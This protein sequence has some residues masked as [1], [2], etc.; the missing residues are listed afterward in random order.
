MYY[1]V[2]GNWN[3]ILSRE[4]TDLSKWNSNNLGA[5]CR[6]THNRVN[7]HTTYLDLFLNYNGFSYFFRSEEW[8]RRGGSC[9]DVENSDD[10]EVT[11]SFYQCYLKTW[12]FVHG[13]CTGICRVYKLP[14]SVYEG[15]VRGFKYRK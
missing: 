6:A 3:R 4:L 2:V 12:L 11:K 9:R 14:L 15:W 10:K 7:R 8:N 13:R 1:A 5:D